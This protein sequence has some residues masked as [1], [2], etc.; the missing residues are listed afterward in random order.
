[1][2]DTKGLDVKGRLTALSE[3]SLSVFSEGRTQTFGLPDVSEVRQQ[4]PDSLLN[5]G[6][7]GLA[8]GFALPAMLCT[9]RSDASETEF[10]LFGTFLFGG[11]PGLGIGLGIDALLTRKVPLFWSPSR[12][13]IQP[14]IGPEQIGLRAF[15]RLGKR[16]TRSHTD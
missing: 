6:L 14:V 11:L 16:G 12:L 2:T 15:V 3:Q 4:I 10:C 1:V 13:I 5:G 7:I 9:S 8:A